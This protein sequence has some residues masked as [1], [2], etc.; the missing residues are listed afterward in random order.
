MYV[1]LFGQWWLLG[2]KH[3][4]RSLGVKQTH[5]Y[6]W[7]QYGKACRWSFVA[8]ECECGSFIALSM[9]RVIQ[10]LSLA[11]FIVNHLHVETNSGMKIWVEKYSP[12]RQNLRRGSKTYKVEVS[13]LGLLVKWHDRWELSSIIT[14]T[15]VYILSTLMQDF[16][17]QSWSSYACFG[18]GHSSLAW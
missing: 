16:N 18:G 9:L 4:P 15:I 7:A 11:Y 2:Q 5:I 6:I 12:L 8:K 10:P 1:G 17:F 13:R 3:P 14:R